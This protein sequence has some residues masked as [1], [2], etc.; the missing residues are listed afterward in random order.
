[1]KVNVRMVSVRVTLSVER[2]GGVLQDLVS[3]AL[4]RRR[5]HTAKRDDD[6]PLSPLLNAFERLVFPT[7]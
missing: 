1:M 3:R 7:A 2:R 5:S 6:T 4:A